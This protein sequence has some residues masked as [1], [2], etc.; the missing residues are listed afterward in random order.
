MAVR[1]VSSEFHK[2]KEGLWATS[3]SQQRGKGHCGW[4][5]DA[6]LE[7]CFFGKLTSSLWT[8][9]S[10]SCHYVVYLDSEEIQQVPLKPNF[11][12]S[13]YF[14]KHPRQWSVMSS[15]LTVTNVQQDEQDERLS[16]RVSS[17]QSGNSGKYPCLPH[18]L[19]ELT[20]HCKAKKPEDL[21]GSAVSGD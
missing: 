16:S 5:P 18:R 21:R 17:L 8:W 7:P 6:N 10:S 15:A 14:E 3:D 9:V 2:L 1:E 20:F 4:G 19:S 13:I 12:K 11:K